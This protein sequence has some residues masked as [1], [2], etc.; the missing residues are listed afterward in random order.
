MLG[1]AV[2]IDGEW[3]LSLAE[4]SKIAQLG[5]PN[6]KKESLTEGKMRKRKQNGKTVKEG[7]MMT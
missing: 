1:W 6:K 2:R 4:K 5:C 3:S 7:K